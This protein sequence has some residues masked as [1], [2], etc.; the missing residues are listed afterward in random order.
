MRVNAFEAEYARA[1]LVTPKARVVPAQL[2][3][4]RS[5]CD[6]CQTWQVEQSHM[7]GPRLLAQ[8]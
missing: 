5:S 1:A 7:Q 2:T 3:E 4:K 6:G 8:F